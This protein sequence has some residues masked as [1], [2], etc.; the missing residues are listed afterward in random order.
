MNWI[1]GTLLKNVFI[2][3]KCYFYTLQQC[4]LCHY[5]QI[6]ICVIQW[7][8]YKIHLWK[9]LKSTQLIYMSLWKMCSPASAN[10]V[11]ILNFVLADVKKH[12]QFFTN[13]D[14]ANSNF[15]TKE[16]YSRLIWRKIFC[17]AANF[18]FFHIVYILP[19]R[20]K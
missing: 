20:F 5:N 1:K 14:Y 19:T 9:I 18:S 4:I 8:L 6:G 2:N 15:F 10:S 17:M 11:T 16:L 13:S 3:L 7:Y 12:R